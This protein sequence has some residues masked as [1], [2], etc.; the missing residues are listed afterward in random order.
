MKRFGTGMADFVG[1]E[2]GATAIEY[3][4]I[5]GLVSMAIVAAAT[6]I[7]LKVSDMLA[8]VLPGLKPK[9]S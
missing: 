7:G 1:D 8:A 5:A 9:D 6:Q 2:R 3:A 4:F